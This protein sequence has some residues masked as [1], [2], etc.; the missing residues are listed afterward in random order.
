MKL[1]Y[2][3][4]IGLILPVFIC[5]QNY[6]IKY[7]EFP[8]SAGETTTN[9]NLLENGHITGNAIGLSSDGIYQVQS[10]LVFIY[11]HL[12]TGIEED[13]HLNTNYQ[14]FANY[15]NPFNPT[16]T[17]DY[18]IPAAQNVKLKVYN[19]L[20]KKVAELVNGNQRAGMHKINF[21]G[22]KLVSG[23]YFYKIE[24]KGFSKVRKMLLVK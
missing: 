16:T 6:Q 22:S 23:Q 1:K 2:L 5:A 13:N 24:T 21:D 14:L 7:D 8:S 17:I 9:N 4:L 15:P 19:L 11:E 3:L 10:G 12:S 18:F 20:G